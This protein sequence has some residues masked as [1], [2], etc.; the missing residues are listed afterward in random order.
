MPFLYTSCVLDCTLRFLMI[1]L[2]LIKKKKKKKNY[3]IMKT[4]NKSWLFLNAEISNNSLSIFESFE[5]MTFASFLYSH[6]LHLAFQLYFTLSF[7]SYL[8]FFLDLV[9]N[10][11]IP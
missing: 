5:K 7:F 3:I 4:T 8:W 10:D 11:C 9:V 2:L 1:F 6:T